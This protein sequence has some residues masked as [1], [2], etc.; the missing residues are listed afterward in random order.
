MAA[1]G[2]HG[3]GDCEGTL[4]DPMLRLTEPREDVH[5]A[6]A[7]LFLG[8]T[9][10]TEEP[11][12]EPTPSAELAPAIEAIV[13]GHLPGLASAW[14]GQYARTVAGIDSACVLVSLRGGRISVE[15][16]GVTDAETG[17]PCK[18]LDE[19]LGLARTLASTWVIRDD[20]GDAVADA[21]SVTL[22]TGSD[23]AA[24]VAAYR[25]LKSIK[26]QRSAL[27]SGL[28]SDTGPLPVRIATPETRDGSAKEKI[29]RLAG[30]AVSFL[31]ASAETVLIGG[32]LGGGRRSVI[33][34]GVHD[35]PGGALIERIRGAEPM[36]RSEPERE[37]EREREPA[38]E[39]ETR[40]QSE[41]VAV[42]NPEPEHAAQPAVHVEPAPSVPGITIDDLLD[43]PT[44]S[45]GDPEPEADAA[46]AARDTLAEHLEGVLLAEARCP[47]AEEVE[48]GLDAEGRLHLLIAAT[49]AEVAGAI[50]TL[51]SAQAWA[52]EHRSLLKLT[53]GLGS[54]RTEHR[55][56]AH[57]FTDQPR[58]VRR[59]LNSATRLHLL[60]HA[61]TATG[62]SVA[63]CLELN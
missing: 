29:E 41:S 51:E 50:E 28:E 14:A 62:E 3:A 32:L 26:Q 40:S 11:L 8:P 35:G 52:D 9:P 21:D 39:P 44:R 16:H 33:Y 31:G 55:P 20:D 57:L 7:D 13:L 23:D 59:L 47:F 25:E 60:H 18:T 22:L 45:V 24:I 12:P 4:R 49:G 43:G 58:R 46:P 37:R 1:G 42:E 19:G 34:D 56:V 17:G 48:L 10:K 15:V 63:V 36:A 2:S 53:S 30:A 5:D 61:A 38:P 54:M 6:L 27:E